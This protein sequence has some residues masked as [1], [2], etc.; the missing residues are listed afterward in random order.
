[1][2]NKKILIIILCAII[3]TILFMLLM[4]IINKIRKTTKDNK[5]IEKVLSFIQKERIK[6][7]EIMF[8]RI[9]IIAKRNSKFNEIFEELS[10]KFDKL[11]I[12]FNDLNRIISPIKNEMK[13]FNKKQFNKKIE[14][15]NQKNDLFEK[16]IRSFKKSANGVLKEEE[17]LRNEM[18]FCREKTRI[19]SELYMRKRVVL[20]KIS[21]RI[22]KINEE[23]KLLGDEF[24]D[25][26]E[27][28]INEKAS[29]IIRE[30][31]KKI[32]MFAKVINEGPKL[33]ATIFGSIPEFIK[34]IID[35]YNHAKTELRVDLSYLNFEESLSNLSVL[36]KKIQKDFQILKIESCKKNSILIIKNIKAIE[37]NINCEIRARNLFIENYQSTIQIAKKTLTQYI[38]LKNQIKEMPQNGKMVSI[39]IRDGLKGLKTDIELFDEAAIAF[40]DLFKNI[41]IPYTSRLSR[42]KI[43]LNKNIYIN[44]IMNNIYELILEG[45]EIKRRVKNHFL[46]SEQA[47]INLRAQSLDKKIML[48]PKEKNQLNDL[49]E[50]K[51]M[52]K[53]EILAIPF[54]LKKS[55]SLANSLIENTSNYYKIV[56]GKIEMANMAMNL[57]KEFSNSRALDGKLNIILIQAEQNYLAGKYAESLNLII[58]GISVFKN[59]RKRGKKNVW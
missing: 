54:N 14:I 38:D 32:I 7:I 1:M 43:L 17:F 58:D 2:T 10:N 27:S 12:L 48:S 9:S 45:E 41:T 8:Q 11:E 6:K 4:F 23:I 20:D 47:L 24:D 59:N 34:K 50:Q 53:K 30:I 22:D 31:R 39:D 29:H 21:T 3:A 36:F 25:S 49:N 13:L 16:Q 44:S 15:I 40:K 52:L 28:G 37:R 51:G 46:Q 19:I 55:E 5:K 56:G 33:Q 35:L 18:S 42:M 26:I 57:I